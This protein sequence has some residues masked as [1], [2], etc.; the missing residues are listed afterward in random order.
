MKRILILLLLFPF[1]PLPVTEIIFSLEFRR[2]DL[3]FDNNKKREN[4]NDVLSAAHQHIISWRACFM[5]NSL[6]Y[7][8]IHSH[9]FDYVLWIF[10]LE[11]KMRRIFRKERSLDILHK[12]F[13]HVEHEIITWWEEYRE[14][15]SFP[16]ANFKSFFSPLL[17][18][19]HCLDFP[20]SLFAMMI[21]FLLLK[22]REEILLFRKLITRL[23]C[24]SFSWY[25]LEFLLIF[26]PNYFW[27]SSSLIHS[28]CPEMMVMF[29]LSSCLWFSR[30]TPSTSSF[31]LV[32]NTTWANE[33]KIHMTWISFLLMFL[34]VPSQL[35]IHIRLLSSSGSLDFF[36]ASSKN[37]SHLGM[38]C[39]F[40]SISLYPVSLSLS[41]CLFNFLVGIW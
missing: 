13:D 30:F 18:C 8:R 17:F 12:W 22:K 23:K 40:K 35:T 28:F 34:L 32:F 39:D 1:S 14:C 27:C 37:P 29:N 10:F 9:Y 5:S 41:D 21:S 25:E 11:I 19:L 15:S 38:S 7:V 6:P 4:P 36:L 31:P 26:L 33:N 20:P 3:F 2:G 24:W 16:R